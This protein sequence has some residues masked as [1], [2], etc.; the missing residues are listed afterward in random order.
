MYNLASD[1]ELAN[2]EIAN[3][4]R[5]RLDGV[6][7]RIAD[8][9]EDLEPPSTNRGRLDSSRLRRDTGFD[10]WTPMSASTLERTLDSIRAR[11]THA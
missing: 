5:R 3:Q 9:A 8:A 11:L 7:L 4:I 6:S 1:E 10:D 2:L